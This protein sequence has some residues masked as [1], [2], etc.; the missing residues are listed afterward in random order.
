MAKCKHIISLSILMAALISLLFSQ[1]FA[2]VVHKL[3]I[4]PA[5]GGSS[6]GKAI[7][8]FSFMFVAVML[9]ALLDSPKNKRIKAVAEKIHGKL[10]ILQIAFLILTLILAAMGFLVQMRLENNILGDAKQEYYTNDFVPNIMIYNSES[11]IF[12]E[13]SSSI[14]SHVLKSMGGALYG[15]KRIM[16]F[17]FGLLLSKI[18]D[19]KFQL[20]TLVISSLCIVALL[21]CFALMYHHDK[22]IEDPLFFM[23]FG[24]SLLI[25]S[26]DGSLF[27]SSFAMF[28]S[29]YV[30]FLL[31]YHVGVRQP[32]SKFSNARILAMRS[33][34]F[35]FS[36]II[37]VILREILLKGSV[38]YSAI[39]TPQRCF[40]WIII[41]LFVMVLS[42]RNALSSL[43]NKNI[44]NRQNPNIK[45]SKKQR[46]CLFICSIILILS[47][48]VLMQN[49]YSILA[50][51]VG[52]GFNIPKT[53]M[54]SFAFS[55]VS[56]KTVRE[57]FPNANITMVESDG[58]VS[59]YYIDLGKNVSYPDLY[60]IQRLQKGYSLKMLSTKIDFCDYPLKPY[61]G[62]TTYQVDLWN[63]SN[64]SLKGIES[65]YL[66]ILS[67]ENISNN[68]MRYEYYCSDCAYCAL[69]INPLARKMSG[70]QYII[71][72]G[73]AKKRMPENLSK[74][75]L[76]IANP[77]YMSYAF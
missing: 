11:R 37:L 49:S 6:Y 4:F 59:L 75:L 32:S 27:Y 77:F 50:N 40:L 3:L 47:L 55:H 60:K 1:R 26:M 52:S 20:I 16:P 74:H 2:E 34:I 62:R 14:H 15:L 5:Y 7:F 73:I 76:W 18:I 17:D 21:L 64:A 46:H 36:S 25:T 35:V 51:E 12:Y 53:S 71:S 57:E 22:N 43:T 31:S 23:F 68:I 41:S 56:E 72:I 24:T 42:C 67:S 38:Y 61:F 33:S 45:L 58:E 28:L 8:I 63:L 54:I 9:A 65:P 48:V 44:I 30:A 13:T 19:T 69:L 66:S 70:N 29:I 10:L 39:A